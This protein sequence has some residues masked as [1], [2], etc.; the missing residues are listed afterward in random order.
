MDRRLQLTGPWPLIDDPHETPA[1]LIVSGRSMEPLIK[2]EAKKE[3]RRMAGEM[4]QA[5]LFSPFALAQNMIAY[6]AREKPMGTPSFQILQEASKKSFVDAILISTRV[7]QQKMV[8]QRALTGKQVGFKVVHDRDDDRDFKVTPEIQRRCDEME[9]F[10][11]DPTPTRFRDYYP[12]RR[13]THDG[14]KDLIARLVKA[15]L[16]LDRKVLQRYPRSDGKGYAAFHW[17][18]GDTIKPVDE[19]VREWARKN[20]DGGKVGRYTAD[21]MSHAVGFDVMDSE[22]VQIVDGQIVATFG[23][24]ELVVKVANPSDELNQWGYGISP[25]EISLDVTATLLYAWKYNQEMFKTNYPEQVLMVAGNVD[26]KGLAAFKQQILGEAGG[27]GSNWRLPV[28]STD[29]ADEFKI[30]AKKLRDS[31]KDMLFDQFFRFMIMFKCSAYGAHPS[32]LNFSLDSGGN[33]GLNSHDPSGEIQFSQD[34]GLKPSLMDLCEWFTNELVKPRYPDLRVILTGLE[35]ED[36]KGAVELLQTRVKNWKTRNE[37]RMVEGDT[38]R[39]FWVPDEK[40]DTLS[41]EDRQKYDSN[42]WNMPAD[43]PLAGVMTQMSM[44]QQGGGGSE[45]EGDPEDMG[46]GESSAK[47][48]KDSDI[49]WHDPMPGPRGGMIIGHNRETG[50]AIYE[51]E[52]KGKGSDMAKSQRETRFLKLRLAT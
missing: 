39:G 29:S 41:D 24:D 18:P 22:Y 4:S 16:I 49:D 33:K 28:I 26:P 9:E 5:Q 11:A 23:D 15:E 13:R 34:Y 52:R 21:R 1:G 14:L 36:E 20:E 3:A 37:A 19:V 42:P 6:G 25:L 50:Q 8:W 10:L 7:K 48:G 43:Q 51:N 35:D 47:A 31:P 32:V 27:I 38:P 12:H 46:G 30:E 2:A 44:L 17:L 40:Y 45:D